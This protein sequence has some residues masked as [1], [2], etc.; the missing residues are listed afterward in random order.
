[1]ANFLTLLFLIQVNSIFFAMSKT[2]CP[3]LW[4]GQVQA[5]TALLERLNVTEERIIKVQ[6]ENLALTYVSNNAVLKFFTAAGVKM[7]LFYRL[8]WR[9]I[10]AVELIK[11]R[12]HIN[13]ATARD[14]FL[15]NI[16][17][18]LSGGKNR[19]EALKYLLEWG[20]SFWEETDYR[21]KEITQKLERDLTQAVDGKAK[22][23]L[24]GISG[25]T[26][27]NVSAAEK[28]TEE[29]RA[30]VVRLGQNVVDRVQIKKLSDVIELLEKIF[31]R[32]NR[33]ST[34]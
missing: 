4:G 8:L 20:S 28:L 14:N 7:E 25:E 13:T 17:T 22:A 3:L 27:F 34:M 21:I 12:Y 31:W 33:K 29:Q 24:V 6:P 19:E 23:S 30:E 16:W 32:I 18:K 10:F 11:E 5:K 26:G 2:Q 9:H 1:M 15:T